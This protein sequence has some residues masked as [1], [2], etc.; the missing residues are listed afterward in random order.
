M[1]RHLKSRASDTDD[2]KAKAAMDAFTGP[3]T[4]KRNRASTGSRRK[5]YIE[6]VR[7]RMARKDWSGVT[8]GKLVALYWCC[9]EKVYGVVPVELDKASTWETAMKRA[10]LMVKQH[11]DNDMERAITF[12]R[13]TWTRE[14]ERE[15]W[16]RANTKQGRR[17]T[18]QNQFI[19]DH[20]ITDWRA[21]AM[22]RGG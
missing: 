16:R 7:D 12:M 9:H 13:W 3:P 15:E 22:R 11:F 14:A 2:T 18:W 8:P 20:L 1:A 17:I 21:E 5:Q 4:T 19:H 10:G 6:E